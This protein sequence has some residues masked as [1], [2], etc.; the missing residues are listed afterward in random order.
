MDR[1]V[2]YLICVPVIGAGI[3]AFPLV[4]FHQCVKLVCTHGTT[5]Y[6]SYTGHEYIHL[7]ENHQQLG[8]GYR[9]ISVRIQKERKVESGGREWRQR[10]EVESGGRKWR[11]K[12]EVESGCREVGRREGWWG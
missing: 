5:Y 10:A 12:A 2:S 4:T 1:L 9:F 11:Q 8:Q 7:R 6:L 3:D